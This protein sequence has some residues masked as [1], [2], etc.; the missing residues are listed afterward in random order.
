MEA[1]YEAE[2]FDKA[3]N[4]IKNFYVIFHGYPPIYSLESTEFFLIEEQI[5]N[6]QK[7]I[8][9]FFLG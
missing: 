4:M 5:Y 7:R 2:K 6:L 1:K 8:D 9:N 3:F